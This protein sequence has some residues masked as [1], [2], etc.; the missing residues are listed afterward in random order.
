MTT[1]TNSPDGFFTVVLQV[2]T[3]NPFGSL[4]VL[5]FIT[6]WL[7]GKLDE[8][9]PKSDKNETT[10][11]DKGKAIESIKNTKKK[12]SNEEIRRLLAELLEKLDEEE[13]SNA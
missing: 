4:I 7:I 8:M 3:N 1:D 13:E 2:L 9:L 11:K 12:G 5:I 6:F 10:E